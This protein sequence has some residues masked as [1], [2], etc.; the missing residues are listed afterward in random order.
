MMNFSPSFIQLLIQQKTVSSQSHDSYP[1]G[2]QGL[3]MERH[4]I[5]TVAGKSLTKG[6]LCNQDT[7]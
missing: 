5:Q 7:M 6:M 1:Q 2:T 4:R 3:V